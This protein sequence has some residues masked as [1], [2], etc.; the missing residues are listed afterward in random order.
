MRLIICTILAI[1]GLVLPAYAQQAA[2]ATVPVGT[3][4]AER[5]AIAKTLEF[6]GRVEAINRVEIKARVTGYLEALLFKEGDFVKEGA[7]LYRIEK[8]LF[9][10]AVKQAEGALERAKS[11]KILTVVQLQ[12]AEELL[13]KSSGTAVARDQALAADEQA[14][15]TILADEANLQT[16]RI[17]LGY[18]DITSSITG[19]VGRTKITKGNV[20]GPDTGPLTVVV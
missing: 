19:K 1:C 18:T 11:A 4:K 17:N 10:A 7:P 5:K 13:V 3:V 14:K 9:D 12:R 16:A 15:G 6:V 20:V 2:P 8:G